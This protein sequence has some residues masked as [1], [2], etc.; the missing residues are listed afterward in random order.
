MGNYL[1]KGN[2]PKAARALANVL[3][4]GVGHG[5]GE[6]FK[7]DVL[8]ETAVERTANNPRLAVAVAARR[9]HPPPKS[10]P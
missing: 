3:L 5:Q 4:G 7:P 10:W 2:S 9:R 1:Q 6:S 8:I